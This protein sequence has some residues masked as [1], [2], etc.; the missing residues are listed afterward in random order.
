M[1]SDNRQSLNER[2]ARIQSEIAAAE[3]RMRETLPLAEWRRL[4]GL[5]SLLHSR[6]VDL[7][8]E[9]EDANGA[10]TELDPRD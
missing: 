8:S 3:S 5:L 2:L 10:V 6:L 4:T 7:R 9:L 1:S